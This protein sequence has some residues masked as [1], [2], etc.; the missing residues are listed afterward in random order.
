MGSTAPSLWV[1]RCAGL[2]PPARSFSLL[3]P[4]VRARTDVPLAAERSPPCLVRSLLM[5]LCRVI[6]FN[7]VECLI[8][9]LM[10]YLYNILYVYT[11]I[12]IIVRA[13]GV[14]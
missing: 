10:I 4:A 12:Y 6:D 8:I 7:G 14:F 13:L 1:V 11:I 9:F 3:P 5:V 2:M